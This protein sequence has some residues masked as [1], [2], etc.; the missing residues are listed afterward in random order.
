MMTPLDYDPS[1]GLVTYKNG[2][3]YSFNEEQW[4]LLCGQLAPVPIKGGLYRPDGS[5][6]IPTI[7]DIEAQLMERRAH[8]ERRKKEQEKEQSL[9]Q[10]K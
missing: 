9:T 3:Q 7:A 4:Y 10:N 8:L 5:L 2:F 1:L 6:H